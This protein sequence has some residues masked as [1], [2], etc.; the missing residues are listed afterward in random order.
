M[1]TILEQK[2]VTK[3][4]IID[5]I[6]LS[7]Q[8]YGRIS[9]MMLLQYCYE[10]NPQLIT[11]INNP[12]VSWMQLSDRLHLTHNAINQ[13]HLLPTDVKNVKYDSLLS[14]LNETKTPL[15]RK[16]LKSM[17]LRPISDVDT[18]QFF[19]NMTEEFIN[20]TSLLNFMQ[21]KYKSLSDLEKLQRKLSLQVIKP[22]ELY[23]LFNSYKLIDEVHDRIS[24][25]PHKNIKEMLL[26]KEQYNNF[27]TALKKIFSQV[28]MDEFSNVEYTNG[29]IITE[30]SFLRE[31][32][33]P[34]IDTWQK[35][36]SKNM[37]KITAIVNHLS[38]F[39]KAKKTK[40]EKVAQIVSYQ[41]GNS[42]TIDES[43]EES[44]ETIKKKSK[45][46]GKM[47]TPFLLISEAKAKKLKN[48]NYDSKLCGVL[49]FGP[50]KEKKNIVTSTVID[51]LLGDSEASRL[52]ML[53]Q[54]TI[55]YRK[56]V[57]ELYD[58]ATF[59]SEINALVAITDYISSN[60][61]TAISNR[62]FK[63][64]IIKKYGPSF[65]EYKNFRHPLI[66]KIIP[67]D[68]V[69][70]DISL[71]AGPDEMK[72]SKGALLLG[73]NSS[74]KCFAPLTEI[75]MYN[76]FVKYA[77]DIA[78]GDLL[79]GDDCTS[80][81]V[82]SLTSG[83]G[84]MFKI[85]PQ[86]GKE[87]IVNREHI[88]CLRSSGKASF[89][90]ESSELYK[91]YWTDREHHL[92][93]R[94]FFSPSAE[95][96]PMT[97]KFLKEFMQSLDDGREIS[98]PD[99][100]LEISVDDFL[101]KPKLWRNIYTLYRTGVNY[102]EKETSDNPYD[103][104]YYLGANVR[105]NEKFPMGAYREELLREKHIPREYMINSYQKRVMLL[106]GFLVAS[107]AYT[108]MRLKIRRCRLRDDILYLLDSLNLKHYLVDD[109]LIIDKNDQRNDLL[110]KVNLKF[111]IEQVEDGPF[112]GF[113]VDGNQRFLLSDYIVTHNSSLTRAI[114]IG[115]IMAQAGMYVPGQLTYRPY[116]K[117]LTRLTGNDD[118]LHGK[119]SFI[120]EMLE[121]RTILRCSDENSLVLADEACRGTENL[122]GS[123]IAISMI[124]TL[125][126]RKST[127]IMST[128]LHHLPTTKNLTV[129]PLE[130]LRVC[131]LTT[132]YDEKD[133]TLVF[134]RKLKDGPG[135]STYGI[136]V[137]KYLGLDPGFIRRAEQTRKM[138]AGESLSL[139]DAKV[140]RYHSGVYIY[141][142]MI[143]NGKI[144]LETHHAE[145]QH[146]A[147]EDGFINDRHKDRKMNLIGLCEKCHRE[148]HRSKKKIIVK[149]SGLGD[150]TLTYEVVKD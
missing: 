35:D 62:Y 39:F 51:K 28:K 8:I 40:T 19:Y 87:F 77:K 27:S 96:L 110:D 116:N 33:Q 100:V 50:Y 144:D 43:S 84:N 25:S 3:I 59:N 42:K 75:L 147:D 58:L 149:T 124:E 67:T 7:D 11:N 133:D 91:V 14:V 85:I 55:F 30:N 88:L 114:G 107:D 140:S 37:L 74:G 113:S 9:Y 121:M 21:H 108:E 136:E 13:L 94:Y 10:H 99:E 6:G 4:D 115:I 132:L 54:L 137:A 44:D 89:I 52:L 73:L 98:S 2:K 101:N 69:T 61:K 126:E 36:I 29:K 48:M 112:F 23:N 45:S 81:T 86:G 65:L 104:G 119:S 146:L 105:G 130:D 83:F 120:V 12:H 102:P 117:I 134:E 82:L 49:K 135:K 150:K 60:A 47:D 111:D 79:M 131:H 129:M 109:V 41:R 106:K 97:L 72:A 26:D 68:Y 139:L 95:M 142:C 31:G 38:D 143:C 103:I 123:A 70:N 78:V 64:Q 17:L 125:V 90:Q 138:L 71:G 24:N 34:N 18:L 16:Y 53:E 1:E 20:D 148:L 128:H 118:M 22:L 5:H 93:F 76:G 15:G 92:Q 127:F 46:P 63:P 56:L 32:V 57:K 122:S 80:R 141:K 145:E 66:E